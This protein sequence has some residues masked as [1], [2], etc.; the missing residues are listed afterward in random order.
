LSE[1]YSVPISS[2]EILVFGGIYD[3]EYQNQ[4]YIFNGD[5]ETLSENIEIPLAPAMLVEEGPV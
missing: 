5:R 3:G 2:T 1:L 4:S